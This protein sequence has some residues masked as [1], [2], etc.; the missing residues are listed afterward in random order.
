[1]IQ[2]IKS[3]IWKLEHRFTYYKTEIGLI[4][5]ID[6]MIPAVQKKVGKMDLAYCTIDLK[7]NQIII[8]EAGK[9]ADFIFF[10]KGDKAPL[11]KQIPRRILHFLNWKCHIRF[12]ANRK[13]IRT[14]MIKHM[15]ITS[16]TE[17]KSTTYIES[18]HKWQML[19]AINNSQNITQ[20]VFLMDNIGLISPYT[21]LL[22]M[23]GE[24]DESKR[25]WDTWMK[26]KFKEADRKRHWKVREQ[27]L[28]ARIIIKHK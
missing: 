16:L 27:S 6:D 17:E 15:F 11:W 14:E 23:I 2:T 3:L 25:I 26:S 9:W 13:T 21:T 24:S 7:T 28:L 12:H 10:G 5:C 19:Y 20:P 18:Y 8:K 22:G 4:I 1:M